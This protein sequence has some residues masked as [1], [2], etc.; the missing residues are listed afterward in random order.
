MANS[1]SIVDFESHGHDMISEGMVDGVSV[2]AITKNKMHTL[3]NSE[4]YTVEVLGKEL[5]QRFREVGE[6]RKAAEAAFIK[7]ASSAITDHAIVSVVEAIGPRP[8]HTSHFI[9]SLTASR[10][11]LWKALI[12]RYGKGG[13]GAGTHYSAFSAVAHALHR[14]AGREILDKLEDYMPAPPGLNWGSP[15]IRYWT[16]PGGFTDQPYPDEAGQGATYEEGAMKAVKV[17]RYERN[18]GAR[19]AC[20]SH[21][22]AICQGCKMDFG[23]RY[24]E[25]GKDFMHVHHLLPLMV[26]KKAYKVDPINDLLPV[27]PNCHAMIHRREPMLSIDDLRAIIRPVGG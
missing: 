27:C 15:V 23:S 4:V 25:R 14:A 20:I 18:R 1:N 16:G 22:G 26:I 11:G 13:Q 21:Y 8:F 5:D 12:A 9:D 7:R 19:A 3:T 17:N 6:A 24:G 2:V 10:P